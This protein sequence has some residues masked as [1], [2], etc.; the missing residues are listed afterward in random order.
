[1]TGWKYCQEQGC[2]AKHQQRDESRAAMLDDVPPV[3]SPES[4]PPR[5]SE[6]G[7]SKLHRPASAPCPKIVSMIEIRS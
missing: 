1:V 5:P 2:G 7:G 3:R 4:A 6:S